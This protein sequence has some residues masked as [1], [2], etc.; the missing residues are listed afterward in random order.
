MGLPFF[1]SNYFIFDDLSTADFLLLHVL[2]YNKEI[3]SRERQLLVH[4]Y[5]LCIDHGIN[6]LFKQH[7]KTSTLQKMVLINL[8]DGHVGSIHKKLYLSDFKEAWLEENND[9]ILS[10]MIRLKRTEKELIKMIH[11]IIR[12]SSNTSCYVDALNDFVFGLFINLYKKTPY[13]ILLKSLE[14]VQSL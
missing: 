13:M 9:N 4:I 10:Q 7:P 5:S 3:R 12:Y 2:F 11:G 6:V 14:M 1:L 8:E